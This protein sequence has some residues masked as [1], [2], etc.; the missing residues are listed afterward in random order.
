M[1]YLRAFDKFSYIALVV[2][3]VYLALPLLD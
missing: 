3:A 1:S 2:F